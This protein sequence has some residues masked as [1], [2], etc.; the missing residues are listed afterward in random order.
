[1]I[2]CCG[3]EVAIGIAD[4]SMA[5]TDKAIRKDNVDKLDAHA[6]RHDSEETTN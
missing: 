3:L 1:M 5:P 2:T 6:T 4:E